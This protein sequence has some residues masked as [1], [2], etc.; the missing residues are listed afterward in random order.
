MGDSGSMTP[1]IRRLAEALPASGINAH[2]TAL[3]DH[4]L[5]WVSRA[6]LSEPDL[7]RWDMARYERLVGRMYPDANLPLLRVAAQAAMWLILVDGPIG[8][9]GPNSPGGPTSPT[10]PTNSTGTNGRGTPE[11]GPG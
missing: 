1:A 3:R 10:G 6:G 11:W 7:A 8:H 9:T 5:A 4:I 2:T